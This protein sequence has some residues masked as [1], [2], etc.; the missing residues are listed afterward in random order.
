MFPV[1]R[2]S[3]A[4][5]QNGAG[6][7]PSKLSKLVI[8]SVSWPRFSTNRNIW[9][10]YEKCH[11]KREFSLVQLIGEAVAD[12]PVPDEWVRS[13]GMEQVRQ[14]HHLITDMLFMEGKTLLSKLLLHT[15]VAWARFKQGSQSEDQEHRDS[16]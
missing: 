14:E 9:H 13:S 12:L 4:E 10:F 6:D 16:V 11:G 1:E 3:G 5:L 15:F 7:F 2:W 8:T